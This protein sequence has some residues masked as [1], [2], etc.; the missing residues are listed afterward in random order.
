MFISVYILCYRNNIRVSSSLNPNRDRH[1][2]CLQNLSADYKLRPFWGL[3]KLIETFEPGHVV[4][5]LKSILMIFLS[6]FIHICLKIRLPNLVSPF[7]FKGTKIILY[8]PVQIRYLNMIYITI[9]KF[10]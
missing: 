8:C 10:C 9:G 4:F 6:A 7:S 3:L 5:L 1:P 2:N